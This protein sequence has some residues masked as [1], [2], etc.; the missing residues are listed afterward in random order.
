MDMRWI[1]YSW[2]VGINCLSLLV[3]LIAFAKL[4]ERPE[5]ITV[6]ILGL[7]YVTIVTRTSLQNLGIAQGLI[8]MN[9][10]I[11]EIRRL[12]KDVQFGSEAQNVWEM[13]KSLA[14]WSPKVYINAF[15]MG[16]ISLICLFVL[17]LK[18]FGN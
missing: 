17:G 14:A 10:Q 13:E 1:G 9:K 11:L 7:I 5:A 8:A 3:V 2:T 6:A 15:F 18:L 12:L 16:L 4:L